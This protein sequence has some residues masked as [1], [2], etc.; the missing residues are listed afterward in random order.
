VSAAD[1][2]L[3]TNVRLKSAFF[4]DGDL[5]HVCAVCHAD[6]PAA[7]EES[8]AEHLRTAHQINVIQYKALF[9]DQ[10]VRES[11]F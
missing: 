10:K 11:K 1:L 7:T 2:R 6:V 5:D 8:L 3:R 9:V 4:L